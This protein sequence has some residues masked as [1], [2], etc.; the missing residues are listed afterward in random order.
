M[1][2]NRKMRYVDRLTSTDTQTKKKRKITIKKELIGRKTRYS[3][4]IK[5]ED[6]QAKKKRKI[7]TTIQTRK[8]TEIKKL[9]DEM[10]LDFLFSKDVEEIIECILQYVEKMKDLKN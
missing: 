4:R 9:K 7:T 6:S 3:T 1:T 8:K 2:S 5:S 10:L